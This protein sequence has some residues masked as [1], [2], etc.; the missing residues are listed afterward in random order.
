MKIITRILGSHSSFL[1]PEMSPEDEN[2]L[3]EL[4]RA[5]LGD[6]IV[7]RTLEFEVMGGPEDE[8]M[9]LPPPAEDL[10]AGIYIFS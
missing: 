2:L 8:L 5:R 6:E 10:A 7:G 1:S 3:N 9:D 4:L